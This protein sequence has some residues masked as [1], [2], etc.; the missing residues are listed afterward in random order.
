MSL[1]QVARVTAA[2]LVL[3]CVKLAVACSSAKVFC[4]M[5]VA[6][7]AREVCLGCKLGAL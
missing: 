4:G 6:E 3:L 1:K 5:F 2:R 7:D